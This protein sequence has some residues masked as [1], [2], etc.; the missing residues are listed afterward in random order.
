MQGWPRCPRA[1]ARP[2]DLLTTA[3]D[4]VPVRRN[5]IDDESFR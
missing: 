3:A 4:V 1:A 5:E 2:G